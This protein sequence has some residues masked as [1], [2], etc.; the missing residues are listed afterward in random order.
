MGIE[1]RFIEDAD[2][3]YEYVRNLFQGKRKRKN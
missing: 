1:K 2:E 3:S